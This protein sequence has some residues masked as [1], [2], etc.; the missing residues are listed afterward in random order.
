MPAAS[1]SYPG[2]DKLLQSGDILTVL[3]ANPG[4]LQGIP[5]WRRINGYE[6]I[7]IS[8]DDGDVIINLKVGNR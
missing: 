6:V 7:N 8:E 5:A 3:C 4:V 2:Q 1:N